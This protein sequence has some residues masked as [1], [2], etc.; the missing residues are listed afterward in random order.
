MTMK[1]AAG[2]THRAASLLRCCRLGSR[3]RWSTD[4]TIRVCDR[5]GVQKRVARLS[6][7]EQ[8]AITISALRH[9]RASTLRCVDVSD[10]IELSCAV[11][12]RRII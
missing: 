2:D 10:C 3:E 6:V 8:M 4:F 12:F 9:P 5:D 11:C 7:N 1:Q